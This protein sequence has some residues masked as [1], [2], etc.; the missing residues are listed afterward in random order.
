MSI[1]VC[2]ARYL[3]KCNQNSWCPFTLQ[4]E[5][6]SHCVYQHRDDCIV[7]EIAGCMQFT[8][9]W[10]E[11]TNCWNSA[12]RNHCTWYTWFECLQLTNKAMS[13]KNTIRS[14]PNQSNTGRLCGLFYWNSMKWIV[15]WHGDRH[16]IINCWNRW[17]LFLICELASR[18]WCALFDVFNRADMQANTIPSVW[19]CLFAEVTFF[20]WFSLYIC[21][22]IRFRHKTKQHMPCATLDCDILTIFCSMLLCVVL[23]IYVVC[24]LFFFFVH[25]ICS[26]STGRLPYNNTLD[27]LNMS[28][29]S[30]QNR[31]KNGRAYALTI[32][33]H[34]HQ[35]LF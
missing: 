29:F 22:N 35:T 13:S 9:R 28:R 25:F 16:W 14:R 27:V 31:S 8:Y 19:R 33:S 1:A 15:N 7:S 23:F 11:W 32:C 6:T 30:I 20:R 4:D 21:A 18:Y 17:W 5:G 12:L 3:A 24:S 2:F 26:G 10:N 34:L